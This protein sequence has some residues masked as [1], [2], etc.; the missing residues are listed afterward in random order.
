MAAKILVN[1]CVAVVLAE[2]LRANGTSAS[3]AS[4]EPADVGLDA[5]VANGEDSSDG[6]EKVT[7]SKRRKRT[8]VSR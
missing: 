5:V 1:I 6:E 7:R 3:L 8:R 2:R 4:L